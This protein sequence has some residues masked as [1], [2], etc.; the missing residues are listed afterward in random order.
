MQTYETPLKKIDL[1]SYPAREEGLVN[2]V[3][4]GSRVIP[5]IK[6]NTVYMAVILLPY[7]FIYRKLR[8]IN[9]PFYD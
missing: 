5:Y 4:I 2:M 6:C 7:E 3:T 9:R 1:V 8:R